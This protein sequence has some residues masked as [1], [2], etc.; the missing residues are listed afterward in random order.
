[1]AVVAVRL[2]QDAGTAG[3]VEVGVV[4]SDA[5]VSSFGDVLACRY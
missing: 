3:R 5:R 2:Q 4:P 1:M